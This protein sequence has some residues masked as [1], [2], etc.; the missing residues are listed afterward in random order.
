M[1]RS[2]IVRLAATA[3]AAALA[4]A[5]CSS[6]SGSGGGGG[7]S[8]PAL[9]AKLTKAM[10]PAADA[11]YKDP[12]PAVTG[13]SK[14]AGKT[15]WYIPLS[16]Q[17]TTTQLVQTSLTEALGTAHVGVHPCS[18][19]ANPSTISSCITNA[20]NSGAA[21]VVFDSIVAGFVADGINKLKAAHIPVVIADEPNPAGDSPGDAQLAYVP[22]NPTQALQVLAQW[23]A[24]DSG[25]KAGV[26][27]NEV[28]DAPPPIAYVQQGFVPTLKSACSSCTVTINKIQSANYSMMPSSTSAALIANP[29][30]KYVV[31]EFDAFAAPTQQGVQQTGKLNAVKG[32]ST[33]G[34]LAQ[35]QTL[36]SGTFLRAD[37]GTNFTYQGWAM[38]DQTLRLLTGAKPVT[39][40]VPLR[41]FTSANVG[42]LE[43]TSQAQTSGAWYGSTAYKQMFTRLW[44]LGS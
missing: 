25:G 18:G 44:G 12:G 5:G 3:G 7:G 41:L 10:A 30:T 34:L 17:I 37:V 32:G 26:L 13:V 38:A 36:K 28:T 39:Y 19:Q 31:S 11:D 9:S 42:S 35:L 23:I 16:S 24:E 40:Q 8:T 6:S 4:L 21:G 15:V 43:L 2:P 22:G 27:V 33:G 14:L 1:L 20:I 29:S